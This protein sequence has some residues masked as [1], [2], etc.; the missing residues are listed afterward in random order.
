[1]DGQRQKCQ[2]F[3]DVVTPSDMMTLM[4]DDVFPLRRIQCA[5]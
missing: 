5:G 3:E 1:M 2:G 4:G